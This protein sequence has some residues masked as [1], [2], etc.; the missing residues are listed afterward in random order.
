MEQYE[1]PDPVGVG[2]FRSYG[3]VPDPYFPSHLVEK[4]HVALLS[5]FY[6]AIFLGKVYQWTCAI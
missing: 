2:P 4:L 6:I 1:A 5:A 3:I